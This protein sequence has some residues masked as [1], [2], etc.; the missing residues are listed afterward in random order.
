MSLVKYTNDLEF[1]YNTLDSHHNHCV[2]RMTRQGKVWER[3]LFKVY[4]KVCNKLSTAIDIGGYIGSH[5]LPMSHYAEKV[6]VFEPHKELY[7]IIKQNIKQ[8]NIQNIIPISVGLSNVKGK[9]KFIER[10][11]GTSRMAYLTR[12]KT[13]NEIEIDTIDN[14]FKKHTNIN[15][16]KIDVEG[17]ELEVLHGGKEV[18]LNNRP[19][20]LIETF[21][22][23][24]HK[25]QTWCDFED[26]TMNS[27]GGDDYYLEPQ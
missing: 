7:Q 4:S 21:K 6:Y 20:I 17:H 1:T 13:D 10:N 12:N 18:I 23:N 19:V 11:T 22:Q 9:S 8:N 5:A 25:I 3:K 24:K 15:L 14:I 2:T 26:Y 16:I 27:M